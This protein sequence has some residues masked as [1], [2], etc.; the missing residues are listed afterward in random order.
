MRGHDEQGKCEE[1]YGQSSKHLTPTLNHSRSQVLG[2]QDE[3]TL[4]R[5][6]LTCMPLW[7]IELR[8]AHRDSKVGDS[9]QG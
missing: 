1:L 4:F 7:R 6:G 2:W 8:T 5:S 9:I 3:S